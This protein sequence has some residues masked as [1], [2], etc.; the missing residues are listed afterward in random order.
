MERTNNKS[1]DTNCFGEHDTRNVWC[2]MLESQCNRHLVREAAMKH[3]ENPPKIAVN[4]EV[5]TTCPLGTLNTSCYQNYIT[6]T[7]NL[8]S[9]RTAAVTAMVFEPGS[10]CWLLLLLL[11]SFISGSI[12][13]TSIPDAKT[14]HNHVLDNHTDNKATVLPFWH[15]SVLF[16]LRL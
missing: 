1:S 13:I 5:Q 9:Q 7:L 2:K 11:L 10:S 16:L 4:R 12:C 6:F 15:K 3:N 8:C 14:S